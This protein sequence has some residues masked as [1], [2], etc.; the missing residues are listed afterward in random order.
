MNS[1]DQFKDKY[2]EG[3]KKHFITNQAIEPGDEVKFKGMD[4]MKC[5]STQEITMN[6]VTSYFMQIRIDGGRPLSL[7]QQKQLAKNDGFET[8]ADFFHFF[9]AP[10]TGKLAYKGKIVHLTDLKY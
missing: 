1:K 10:R 2:K 7:K 4:N 9:K 3:V 6:A 8:L 5:I